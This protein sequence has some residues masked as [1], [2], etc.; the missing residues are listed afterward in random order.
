MYN[1]FPLCTTIGF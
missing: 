1:V